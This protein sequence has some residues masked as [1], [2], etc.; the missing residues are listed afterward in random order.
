[1]EVPFNTIKEKLESIGNFFHTLIDY[2]NPFSE[3]WF[4]KDFFNFIKG[5]LSYINPFDENFIFREFFS[6]FFS[7]FN[8]FSDNFILKKLWEFLTNIISYINPFDD[9]FLGKKIVELIG[10]LLE[11]LFIPES[12]PFEKLS[13]KFDEK[14]AFVNQIKDLFSKLLGFSNYGEDVPN[15]SLTWYGTTVA[16][17]DFSLFLNYRTWIHGIILAIAWSVFIFKTYRKLPSIIGGFSQ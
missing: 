8:P 16:I 15:F 11:T 17:I 4:L 9:N 5:A 10:Q 1:M 14:F 2:I 6:N 3:N 7:W 12:N 13:S